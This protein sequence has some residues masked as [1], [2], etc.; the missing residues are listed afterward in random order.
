MFVIMRTITVQKGYADQV[1][2]RFSR[3]GIMQT[4]E[5]FIDSTVMVKRAKRQDE[6]DEVVIITRW[7][8][9]EDWKNWE[10]S[11]EHIEGHRKKQGQ[12][13]PEYIVG[14]IHAQY[15]VKVVNGEKQAE[16]E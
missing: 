15:D 1:V 4:F 3:R 9:E 11:P 5:G 12:T 8:S 16:L 7:R 6:Y 13:P 10:K 2:E 14:T